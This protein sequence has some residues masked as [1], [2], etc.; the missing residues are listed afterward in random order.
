M[1]AAEWTGCTNTPAY[2]PYSS[3][4]ALPQ[5]TTTASSYGY[6]T[7]AGMADHHSNFHIPTGIYHQ[8]SQFAHQ[9][10]IADHCSLTILFK[11]SNPEFVLG[12]QW[13]QKC[14]TIIPP[15][16]IPQIISHQLWIHR[17]WF[18][19]LATVQPIQSQTIRGAWAN[20]MKS[21]P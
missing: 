10:F 20:S 19:R 15:N 13:F 11:Y 7:N 17:R 16:I 1:G 9:R 21:M 14:R 6:E 5:P 4:A 18:R 12:F 3:N 8:F 2:M